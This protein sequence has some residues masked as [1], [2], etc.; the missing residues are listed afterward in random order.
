MKLGLLEEA[1]HVLEAKSLRDTKK[2]DG[3]KRSVLRGIVKLED[4]LLAGTAKS[5][6]CTLILTEGDSAATSAISGLKEVGRERWGVFP[7]RGKLLNVRDITPQKFN[8]N[9]ELTAIK[10]ILG[11]EQGRAYKDASELRYGRVMIMADQDHDGSHIK[12]LLMNLFHAEWTDFSV[13][14]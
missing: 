3:K 4:A 10:K 9:E 13:H 12:G 14:C 8:A 2:T 1:K 5:R 11:L 7:L 6:E